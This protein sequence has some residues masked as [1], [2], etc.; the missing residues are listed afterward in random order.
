[1]KNMSLSNIAASCGGKLLATEEQ[2][3]LTAA[4]IVIDSRLCSE[5]FVFVATRGERVD[6]H[7]F[8]GMVKEKGALAAVCETE[9]DT[10]T[11]TRAD[12]S[13]LPVILVEDSFKALREIAAFYRRQ[14]SCKVVG[15]TGSVGK[16]STKEVIASVLAQKFAVCKTQGNFNNEIGVPLTVF[17]IKDT[18]EIAVLEMGINHFGEMHRLG[19]IAMPDV[20]VYTNIGQ[21][22]LEFLGSRDGIL[23]AK[24]EMFDHLNEGAIAVLNGD[25]DKLVTVKEVA[26]KAPIFFGT[27][28]NNAYRAVNVAPDSIFGSAF[29]VT[30]P[31]GSFESFMPL[32]GE[33]MVWNAVAATAVGE[34]FGMTY[35]EIDAG[36][37][38]VHAVGG[39]SNLIRGEKYTII[40]DCYNANPGSMKSALALLSMAQTRKV[41][42][43]GDMFELGENELAL[44]GSV[45]AAAAES[46]IDVLVCI[47]EMSKCM[48]EKACEKKQELGKDAFTVLY[49]ATKEVFLEGSAQ[50]LNVGD[51][52]LVKASNGMKF[53]AIVEFLQQ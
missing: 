25:D 44:H 28:E 13:L 31:N 42:V 52:V 43:L 46:D 40:D 27:G 6:G 8:I 21:C 47:G 17:S 22:H 3:A 51:T 37:R 18:D 10:E 12:G 32:P 33:H 15:I 14:L 48:Y 30:T 49:F 5:N 7:S 41:A 26:G 4:G 20:C 45:G 50:V 9:P 24:T 38:S 35:E 1:M 53:K 36:I 2:A 11:R 16:T 19:E 23:K 34:H 29:T 39:R